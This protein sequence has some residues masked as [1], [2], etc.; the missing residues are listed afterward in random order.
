MSNL[1]FVS[2]GDFALHLLGVRL[3]CLRFGR[4]VDINVYAL[5]RLGVP[6]PICFIQQMYQEVG[7]F[8]R[9]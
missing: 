2:A 3:F 7:T 9:Q 8:Y 4:F 6:P 5:T 1:T